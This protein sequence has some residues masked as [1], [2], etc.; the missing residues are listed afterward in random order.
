ML[1]AYPFPD[2]GFSIGSETS[3]LERGRLSPGH[4]VGLGV[5]IDPKILEDPVVVYE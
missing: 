1:A 3:T 5:E 4:G 2:Q